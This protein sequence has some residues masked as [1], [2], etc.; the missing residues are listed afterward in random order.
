MKIIKR[1]GEEAIFD[2]QKIINAIEK[3]NAAVPETDRISEAYI[4]AVSA[5]VKDACYASKVEMNVEAIQDLVE[6]ELMRIGA[7][8]IARVYI[9]LA[10]TARI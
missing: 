1:N 5:K 4:Q 6:T 9:T 8:H 2:V 10:D 3:A 7:F